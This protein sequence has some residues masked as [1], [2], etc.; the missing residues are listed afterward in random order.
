M[1]PIAIVLMLSLVAG[2]AYA[3]TPPAGD[4]GN[5]VIATVLG[6]HI[7][8]KDKDKLGG[9]IFGTL[10]ERFANDH[11][12][13]ATAEEIDTFILKTEEKGQQN[14][15]KFES[16]RNQLTKELKTAILTE[17]ERKEKQS[18]LQTIERI[19]KMTREMEKRTEGNEAQLLP[20][21]RKSSRPFVRRW[22]INK[23]LF[24]K[25]GGRVIFQQAG[26]E[27]LDAY[28]GFLQEQEK[29]GAFQILDEKYKDAFWRYFTHDA[30]HNFY[31]KDDGAKF[32][33][34]PWWMMEQPAELRK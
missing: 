15:L 5:K 1:K 9:L 25:Y 32:I 30:M 3:Q 17:R 20:L 10:L 19:L 27:P 23:A 13:I 14:L 18:Q 7:T 4:S 29:K 22:K 34:T 8:A 33:N 31:D 24:A 28:R 21:K 16:D 2:A 6:K 12:I 11:K 26:P